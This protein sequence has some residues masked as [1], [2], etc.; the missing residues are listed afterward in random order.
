MFFPST[1]VGKWYFVIGIT[2]SLNIFLDSAIKM[3]LENPLC[4][5]AKCRNLHS[6]TQEH[7]MSLIRDLQPDTVSTPGAVKDNTV[8][9]KR[10]SLC[11]SAFQQ[12]S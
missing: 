6:V 2:S 10:S 1:Y 3:G 5:T 7:K 4:D 11:V 8:L 9:M 12:F